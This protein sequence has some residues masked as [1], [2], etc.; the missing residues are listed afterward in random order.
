MLGLRARLGRTMP[1]QQWNA[2]EA[3][4]TAMPLMLSFQKVHFI[5][6][7]RSVMVYQW[8]DRLEA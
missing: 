8:A 7:K 3:S 5:W 6:V 1:Q 4:S 2:A